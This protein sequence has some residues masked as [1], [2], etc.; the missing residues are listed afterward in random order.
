METYEVQKLVTDTHAEFNTAN[1]SVKKVVDNIYNYSQQKRRK[2]SEDA[3]K[4]LDDPW[5]KY[6][7]FLVREDES[8]ALREKGDQ[9]LITE[10]AAILY[11]T[12]DAKNKVN[13]WGNGGACYEK[14]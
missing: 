8:R 9:K 4:S 10:A 6:A 11:N 5:T 1:A 7:E 3:R 12:E 2:A 14:R 13:A